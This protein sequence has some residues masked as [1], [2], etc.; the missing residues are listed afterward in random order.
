M[1]SIIKKQIK[2]DQLLKQTKPVISDTIQTQFENQEKLSN[3]VNKGC[4]RSW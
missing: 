4:F 3:V 1:E 2:R